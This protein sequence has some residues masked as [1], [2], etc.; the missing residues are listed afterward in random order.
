MRLPD[1]TMLMHGRT[2]YDPVKAHEYYLRTRELKGRK[3]GPNAG[4][5]GQLPAKTP[6]SGGIDIG[7]AATSVQKKPPPLKTDHKTNRAVL[8]DATVRLAEINKQLKQK[9]AK[10]QTYHAPKKEGEK[11]PADDKVETPEELKKRIANLK[12]R[13]TSALAKLEKLAE[14]PAP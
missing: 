11:K 14:P 7:T 5:T 13:L 4:R 8:A 1:G 2:P 10:V 3:K 9:M 6:K 12:G